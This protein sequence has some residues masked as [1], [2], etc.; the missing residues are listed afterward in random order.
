ML[1]PSDVPR[2]KDRTVDL[3]GR[4]LD[5]DVDVDVDVDEGWHLRPVVELE[6][7]AYG[8][9]KM[10]R[11]GPWSDEQCHFYWRTCLAQAGIT[12][13][14]PVAPRSWHVF[15]EQIQSPAT[16]AKILQAHFADDGI[17]ADPEE[18]VALSGGFALVHRREV[19]VLPGCCGDLGNLTDWAK[20]AETE[21]AGREP[22]TLWIGHPWL[23]V[24][25]EGDVLCLREA[26]EPP[27]ESP[28][29]FRVPRGGVRQAVARAKP[30]VDALFERILF[31]L[32]GRESVRDAR[33][34]AK[35]LVGR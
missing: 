9:C 33:A 14:E 35:R 32:G 27:L 5:V 12:E 11:A 8:K 3:G 31:S 26:H 1:T 10:P 19:V 7:G 28:R 20:A 23:S 18:V 21:S 2:R 30:E 17:P 25:A 22:T 16:L 13:L 6:P 34:V 29:T 15:A 24:W 4:H